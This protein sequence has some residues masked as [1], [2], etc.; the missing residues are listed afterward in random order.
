MPGAY[1]LLFDTK[2][3]DD[4]LYAAVMSIE[5]EEALDLPGALQIT[6]PVSATSDGDLTYVADARFGPLVNVA[7]VA[8]P[9]SGPL[10]AGGPLA[11][12]AGASLGGA[13]GGAAGGGGPKGKQCIFDGY[14][15]SQKLKLQTGTTDASLEIWGQDATWLMN[16]EERVKEWVD[17]TDADVAGAIFADYGIAPA[18]ANSDEDSAAHA[19]DGH[20]LM[21]RGSD[22]RFLRDLARRTGKLCRV[23]CADQPGQ[24]TGWFA[25]P[26]L[27]GDPVAAL[28]LND[29]VSW[30]VDALDFAWD[31]S[32]PTAVTARQALFTDS[33]P[34]GANG[35][36]AS[37]GLTTLGARDLAT[38]AGKPM[39]VL[40]A[41]PVDDGG[42]LSMRA[43]AV[44][45]DADWFARCEGMA[46]LSRLGVVLRAGA[47]VGVAGVGAIFSGTYLVWSVRHTLTAT[48][49]KMSF[50]L[51]RNAV[52]PAAGGAGALSS[53][54]NAL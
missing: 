26:K 32:R 16:L 20:S 35:D 47:L 37:S 40:L 14:V 2:P 42:E 27:D 24:R 4:E 18:S 29:P 36:T 33:D 10:D 5:V 39:T 23:F 50:E 8:D 25:A 19:E 31:V 49:H 13:L 12:A 15:L 6:V 38:F 3:A 41:A 30:N 46:D 53:L 7:V 52:G 17:V 28:T 11:G 51:V 9:G 43:R 54:L 21:Q 34:G 1:T 22:I 48:S 45:R 44:L